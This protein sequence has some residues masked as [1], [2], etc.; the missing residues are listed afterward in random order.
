M[1]TNE[2]PRRGR[3]VKDRAL[4]LRDRYWVLQLRA[5]TGLTFATLERE[6]MPHLSVGRRENGEGL[7]QPFALSK[8]ANGSRGLSPYVEDV[9]SL[10]RRAED[11]APGSLAAYTSIL[12][13]ALAPPTTVRKPLATLDGVSPTV[14]SRM[15]DRF[16]RF[17]P[18]EPR[19]MLNDLG[20]RRAARLAHRDALG[21][22]LCHCP[23]AAD[24]SYT[25]L[26]AEL[27]V[28]HVLHQCCK[29]DPTMASLQVEFIDLAKARYRG[30]R[31]V[32]TAPSTGRIF[33]AP[34]V[35][36]FAVSMRRLL[37][38]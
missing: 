9:P 16:W 3:P 2:L 7:S 10:V 30:L 27:Y 8:V 37:G 25:A 18:A 38:D 17:H 12:W 23:P 4:V 33:L 24:V 28:F 29:Q 5:T 26:L 31:H 34:R 15:G 21:L 36:A 1:T 20:I 32:P 19:Q 13:H 6:L 22:L 14:A 11:V 35:R